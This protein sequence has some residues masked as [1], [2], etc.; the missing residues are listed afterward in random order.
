[1]GKI[2][3]PSSSLFD[4][5]VFIQI[6]RPVQDDTDEDALRLIL[7]LFYTDYLLHFFHLLQVANDDI[8]SCHSCHRHLKV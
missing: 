2:A 7:E 6:L 1:M 8:Y 3:I 5:N 4:F